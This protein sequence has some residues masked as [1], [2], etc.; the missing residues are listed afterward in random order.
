MSDLIG[1]MQECVARKA[2]PG[3]A[4]AF[5]T[6]HSFEVVTAGCLTYDADSAPVSAETV[7][8]L[9][10]LT[11]VVAS[12]PLV[13]DLGI[14]LDPLVRDTWDAFQIPATIRQ[15]LTHSSGLVSH[16]QYDEL[17]QSPEHFWSL[18][19]GEGAEYPADTQSVYSCVGFLTLFQVIQRTS[20][21]SFAE[22]FAE[23]VAEPLGMRSTFH[24][25][26]PAG[27]RDRARSWAGPSQISPTE[28]EGV[29]HDEN[30][31]YAGGISGNAGLF[32]TAPDLAR[33]CQ[34]MLRGRISA[35]WLRPWASWTTRAL[36][37]DTKS[38]S[39]SSAGNRFGPRS[40][41]H[42]G[43]TGTSIWIDPD[44][45]IFGVLLTNR[46]YPTRENQSQL[47]FRPE[48]YDR[49]FGLLRA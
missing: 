22:L 2:F 37:W 36:G 16:R 15:L 1:W 34:A 46:V 19:A 9:A 4:A 25:P 41:G 32:G 13:H 6:S 12:T 38:P 30:S 18:I 31:R 42:T 20:G 47:W 33:F 39:G 49:I 11:K 44:A 7:Y 23:R 43:Y 27:C 48:F 5:G 21:R 10:S 17:A 40:Y 45:G 26:V 8:D 35:D 28:V 14:P 29:V 24:I 3:C